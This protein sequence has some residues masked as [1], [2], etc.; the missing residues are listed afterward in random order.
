MVKE[1]STNIRE[2]ACNVPRMPVR[3]TYHQS[4]KQVSCMHDQRATNLSPATSTRVYMHV[5]RVAMGWRTQQVVG[6]GRCMP[7]VWST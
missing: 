6:L 7:P 1:S 4:Q 3:T 2:L 5:N